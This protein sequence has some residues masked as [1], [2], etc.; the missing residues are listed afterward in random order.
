MLGPKNSFE[1]VRQTLTAPYFVHPST[2]Q[3]YELCPEVVIQMEMVSY[4]KGETDLVEGKGAG[5]TV[6]I[7]EEGHVMPRVKSFFSENL[8]CGFGNVA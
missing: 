4:I 5:V 2:T 8:I 7:I 6:I 3:L 1:T